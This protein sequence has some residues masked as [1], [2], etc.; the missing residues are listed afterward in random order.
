[1]LLIGDGVWRDRYGRD[2]QIVGRP[3]RVNGAAATIVGVMPPGLKFPNHEDLWMPLIPDAQMEKRS[4]RPLQ[5]FGLLQRGTSIPNAGA[6]LAVIAQRLAKTFPDANKDIGPLVR[7][8]HDTYNGGQIRTVFFAMLGAVGFVLLIACA[9][10]ANL[11]LSRAIAR[12]REIAV[13]AAVGASRWQ[14]VR[15]LLVESVLLSV[16]GGVLGLGLSALGVHAFDL[17]TRDV[18]KP[19]W[20]EFTMDYVAFVYFAA[21]SVLSG[22]L[23]GLAPALRA[24]RVDL[25]TALKEGTP[26]TGGNAG[27]KLTA[28]LVVLQF[29]LTVV[30]LAGAGLMVRGF[31]AARTMNAFVPAEHILTARISLPTGKDERYASRPSRQQ[32]YDEL[33]PRLAAMPG[34]THAAATTDLPGLGAGVREVEVE[35]KPLENPPAGIR[36]TFGMH[37][38]GY[39]AA[40]GLPII[41]GREFNATD[42]DAGREAAVVSRE[43]AAKIWP[44][45]NAIGRRFRFLNGKD[46]PPGPWCSVVGI[47]GD[48]VQR[49]QNTLEPP[50]VFTPARQDGLAGSALLIRTA[51]DPTS[52]AASLRN[53]VQALDQNLPVFDV[54]TLPTALERGFWHLKVFGTLFATF[55]AIALLM[56]S[57]GLYAV[58]AQA[59]ARRT[60]EIGIRMA[61]G[62]TAGRIVRLVLSRGLWQLGIGLTLGLGGAFGLTRLIENTRLLFRVSA[63]DPMVFTAITLL[64]STIGVFACW[65][66]ARRAAALHPVTAL[67]DE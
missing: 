26:S 33:L 21:I 12:G 62:A 67:R 36:V 55:A 39:L 66:P 42:G 14:L 57:V 24:S 54:R 61:L 3:V 60:R 20:I 48:I 65:L 63:Q 8:F 1:V 18:G 25:N 34:V 22:V 15:Q 27:G 4:F 45:E 50:V 52:L 58:V 29:A 53:A 7:T 17:A 13:R 11:M 23:F 43:F 40:I 19:Y 64:L 28:T 47:C 37:T 9:N 2:P 10:V 44:N 51:G 38:P 41:S 6:D 35:G 32:F 30:L 16:C 5:V 49:T 31:F 59:T 46:K 56:A